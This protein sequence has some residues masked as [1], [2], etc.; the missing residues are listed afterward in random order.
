M[1]F[2]HIPSRG[3]GLPND[4]RITRSDVTDQALIEGNQDLSQDNN[5]L[6]NVTL[7]PQSLPNSGST[8]SI[9]FIFASFRDRVK[10]LLLTEVEICTSSEGIL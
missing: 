1:Y 5:H 10:S 2:Y 6:R 4:I 7:V 9:E 3:I 8:V